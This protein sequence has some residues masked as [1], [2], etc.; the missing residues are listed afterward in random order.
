MSSQFSDELHIQQVEASKN[1]ENAFKELDE[2]KLARGTLSRMLKE[3]ADRII[4]VKTT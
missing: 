3:V 1:L 2:T 4:D